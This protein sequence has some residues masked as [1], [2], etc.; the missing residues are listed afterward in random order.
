M[1]SVSLRLPWFICVFNFHHNNLNLVFQALTR[2]RAAP[3]KLLREGQRLRGRVQAFCRE[4]KVADASSEDDVWSSCYTPDNGVAV[5][6]YSNPS[7]EPPENAT[8]QSSVSTQRMTVPPS[9]PPAGSHP[10]LPLFVTK[11][12]CNKGTVYKHPPPASL[13]VLSRWPCMFA[14]A[15]ILSKHSICKSIC[16]R[17]WRANDQGIDWKRTV[18]VF[19]VMARTSE[20]GSTTQHRLS[21]MELTFIFMSAFKLL[22]INQVTIYTFNSFQTQF[23]YFFVLM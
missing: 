5:L 22:P 6:M 21:L 10:L 23:I 17:W 8:F 14:S 19:Q 18:F 13:G 11:S 15:Q 1:N 2:G 16:G 9:Q 20:F 12:L 7:Q 4:K 3:V